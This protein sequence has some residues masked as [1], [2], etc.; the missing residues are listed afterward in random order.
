MALTLLEYIHKSG[1]DFV[2]KGG[3]SLILLFKT[4]WSIFID[5]DILPR[6]DRDLVTLPVLK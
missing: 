2:F 6:K 3:T 4:P 5:I 1:L